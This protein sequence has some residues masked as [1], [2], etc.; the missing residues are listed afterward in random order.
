MVEGKLET[1]QGLYFKNVSYSNYFIYKVW[2]SL[3]DKIETIDTQTLIAQ[4]PGTTVS[5]FTGEMYVM[6]C[7]LG[8]YFCLPIFV[9]FFWIWITRL[10]WDR[11]KE[12]PRGFRAALKTLILRQVCV[13]SIFPVMLTQIWGCPFSFEPLVAPS[14]EYWVSLIQILWYW[15]EFGIWCHKNVCTL[16][17]VKSWRLLNITEG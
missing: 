9:S 12:V 7:I 16:T 6:S 11:R 8:A 17:A 14:K 5:K 3:T 10:L 13:S 4:C 15:T 1:K 2:H